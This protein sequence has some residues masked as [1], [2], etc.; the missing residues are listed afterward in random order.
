M[1]TVLSNYVNWNTVPYCKIEKN[2]LSK[3]Q[4]SEGDIVFARTGATTGKSFLVKNPPL[5]AV[6]ASYLIKL[7]VMKL[8]KL[9]P[10][11]LSLYFQ[12]K[13]YWDKI[14]IGISGS[15][16]GGFNASKLADI[17][18]PIPPLTEQRSIVANL[19]ALSTET[20]KLE[21]I[22]NQKLTNLEE[23]KSSILQKAFNGEL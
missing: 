15:A 12:T 1:L 19:G 13:I 7:H 2:K 8:E 20:K 3:Y 16:Q 5:A 11:F 4:L 21:A 23:L 6:F 17:L 18:I 10:D 22:Y 14:E 9:S